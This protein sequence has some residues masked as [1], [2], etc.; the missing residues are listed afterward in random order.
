MISFLRRLQR[1]FAL[2]LRK[3]FALNDYLDRLGPLLVER[4]GLAESYSR[5]RIEQTIAK[6][7]LS[8]RYYHYA[9][10][11]YCDEETFVGW[12]DERSR[13][14][15]S[16]LRRVV[17]FGDPYRTAPVRVEAPSVPMAAATQ[18]GL[19]KAYAD[20]FHRLRH[21]VAEKYNGGSLHFVPQPEPDIPMDNGDNNAAAL[22]YGRFL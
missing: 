13:A 17:R 11:M 2:N 9:L 5:A 22:R 4:Y 21:E 16:W 1:Q 19:R 8:R 10:A 7:S 15:S 20:A 14:S 6:Y 3:R 12:M 18:R